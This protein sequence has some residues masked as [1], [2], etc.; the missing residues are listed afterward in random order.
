M[1]DYKIST[2]DCRI[3]FAISK[4]NTIREAARFMGC[5]PSGLLRKV[6]RISHEHDLL[7]KIEGRWSPTITGEKIISWMHKSIEEQKRVLSLKKDISIGTMS[8]MVEDYLLGQLNNLNDEINEIESC[9]FIHSI[10]YEAAIK[11]SEI[12]FVISCH[13]PED[14]DIMHRRI[15]E[16]KWCIVMPREWRKDFFYLDQSD[17]LNKLNS[18]PY[19]KHT[20]INERKTLPFLE[21]ERRPLLSTNS[22][23][24]VR[25]AVALGLG[26]SYIPKM[27]Y[28]GSDLSEYLWCYDYQI[29]RI[30]HYSIWKLRHRKDLDVIFAKLSD[31]FQRSFNDE[32]QVSGHQKV[33]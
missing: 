25:K 1:S 4:T 22:L 5:D 30:S 21:L 26:W 17:F 20:G 10:D 28:L 8:W 14:P 7:T 3:V 16:E 2:D 23:G 29:E 27:S 12:D 31:W 18:M 6:H 32:M 19:I 33:Q 13:P 24:T 15:G 11:K 9:S